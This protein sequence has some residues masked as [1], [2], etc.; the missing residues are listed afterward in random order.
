MRD[1]FYIV[2]LSNSSMQYYPQN[3]TTHFITKLPQHVNLP[4]NWTVALVD[5]HFPLNF[6]NVSKAVDNRCVKYSRKKHP[7]KEEDGSLIVVE[8]SSTGASAEE[9][10]FHV[11]PGIYTDLKDLIDELNTH[12]DQ[13]HVEF[14][15]K[16]GFYV[17]A[18][19]NCDEYDECNFDTHSFEL[20][21]S[22]KKILG[23]RQDNAQSLD[24]GNDEVLGDFPAN[25]NNDLPRN[26]LVYADICQP[27]I[28]GDVYSRLSR[29]V[30]LDFNQYTYGRTMSVN[31]SRPV[32]I[33]VLCS[34][35]ETIE[36]LISNEVGLN[37]PFDFGTSTLTLHFKRL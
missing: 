6:Q 30:A 4:G 26:L 11:P 10:Q 28:T 8:L 27:Y 29:S 34:S 36:I 3:T 25:I 35:F 24:I 12:S 5:I 37:V 9:G 21:K 19:K 31:F 17:A 32:Y 1:D 33:P 13:S 23:F 16:P 22:L 15:L 18:R 14:S 2:L 7:P 20:S